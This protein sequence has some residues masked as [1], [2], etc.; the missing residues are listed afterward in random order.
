MLEVEKDTYGPWIDCVDFVGKEKVENIEGDV[1]GRIDGLVRDPATN[2]GYFVV[3]SRCGSPIRVGDKRSLLTVA[4][5]I[6]EC[7][8]LV[9]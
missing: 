4:I 1:V 8:G 6:V 9:A 5:G 2:A 3:E 7:I